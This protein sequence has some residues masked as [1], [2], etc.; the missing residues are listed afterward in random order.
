MVHRGYR[1]A[2][3]QGDK[4]VATGVEERI[5]TD[6]K[7]QNPLLSDRVERRIDFADGGGRQLAKLQ[8]E[9]T[10]RL[11]RVTNLILDRRRKTRIPNKAD[12]FC[13]RHELMQQS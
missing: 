2:R 4:L 8:G 1:V 13:L 12:S 5:G 10:R 6:G 9:R 11:F 7:R 3:C